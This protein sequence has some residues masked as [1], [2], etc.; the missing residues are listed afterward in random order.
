MVVPMSLLR[1]LAGLGLAAF[2]L[3][4]QPS[5]NLSQVQNVYILPMSGGMHQ[6][7]AARLVSLGL[8]QI[9]TDPHRADAI[10]TDKLNEGFESRL[11]DYDKDDAERAKAPEQKKKEQDEKTA[12]QSGL[13]NFALA[14]RPL[15]T[16]L[17]GG[18]G[19]FF[20]VDRKSRR[21]LWSVYAKPKNSTPGELY[22]VA[23]RVA[24]K[25]KGDWGAKA[26]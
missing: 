8:F 1:L 3:S 7:L 10:L 6:H 12:D 17:G 14:E 19:T 13:P 15:T 2:A 24:D 9:V 11:A 25:L 23:G 5:A 22:R 26:K 16:S 20:L 4:A 21:L 18:K